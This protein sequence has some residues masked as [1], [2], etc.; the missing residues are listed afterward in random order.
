MGLFV[1]VRTCQ[2]V[3]CTLC[4]GCNSL[5]KVIKSAK[6]TNRLMWKSKTECVKYHLFIRFCSFELFLVTSSVLAKLLGSRSVTINSAQ[7]ASNV[8]L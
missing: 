8:S 2:C 7:I 5:R 6:V 1:N 4:N 3:L